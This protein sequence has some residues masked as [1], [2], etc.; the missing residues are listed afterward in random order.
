MRSQPVKV[1]ALKFRRRVVRHADVAREV[2][3]AAL[4]LKRIAIDEAAPAVERDQHVALIHVGNDAAGPMNLFEHRGEV[5][6]R[7]DQK[8]P[9]GPRKMPPTSGRVVK[10]LDRHEGVEPRHQEPGHVAAR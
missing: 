3:L 5:A 8:R 6:G 9:V 1:A 10:L 4:N 7:P 2:P